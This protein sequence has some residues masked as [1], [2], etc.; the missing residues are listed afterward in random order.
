MWCGCVATFVGRV[1]YCCLDWSSHARH[2]RR[3]TYLGRQGLQ[4]V[5]GNFKDYKVGANGIVLLIVRC[6]LERGLSRQC[7][8]PKCLL[9]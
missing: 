2:L 6:L 1:S 5:K 8:W 3:C 4:R 7:L 9:S